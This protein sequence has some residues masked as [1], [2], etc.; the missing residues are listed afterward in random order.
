[1]EIDASTAS[2]APVVGKSVVSAVRHMVAIIPYNPS[3][4]TPRGMEIVSRVRR[5]SPDRK[6]V[7]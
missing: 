7:V 3:P 4:M 5:S 6:S 2:G 1:M